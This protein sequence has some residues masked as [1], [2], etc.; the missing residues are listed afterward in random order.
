MLRSLSVRIGLV[1]F[2]LA[3]TAFEAWHEPNSIWFWLFAGVTVYAVVEF[4]V[5]DKY[6]AKKNAAPV[7]QGDV[8]PSS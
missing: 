4:F 1:L 5:S 7:S 8:P 6:R 3:W 2:C